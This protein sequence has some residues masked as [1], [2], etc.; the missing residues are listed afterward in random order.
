MCE[1]ASHVIHMFSTQ[2]E[3]YKINSFSSDLIKQNQVSAIAFSLG[4]QNASCRKY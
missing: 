1:F 2:H 4:F 3:S